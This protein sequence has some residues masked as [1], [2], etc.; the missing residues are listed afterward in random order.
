M[1]QR[2]KHNSDI[3]FRCPSTREWRNEARQS[4]HCWWHKEKI[5]GLQVR[6]GRQIAHVLW[7]FLTQKNTSNAE[8]PFNLTYGTEAMIPAEIRVP[9]QRITLPKDNEAER[10]LDLMLLEERKE[11]AAMCEQNYKRQLHKYYNTKE[12]ICEFNAR[13]YVI[14]NNDASRAQPHL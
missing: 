7:A 4:K 13:D 12:K 8:T 3:H 2:V 10:R 14:R 6:L 9:S 11:M 5:G 1:A